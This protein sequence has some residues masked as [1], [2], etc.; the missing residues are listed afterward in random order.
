MET[1]KFHRKTGHKGGKNVNKK[2]V[3]PGVRCLAG[4]VGVFGRFVAEL[5]GPAGL[6]CPG[7][8]GG[9]PGR[10]SAAAPAFPR[11]AS[12]E[13]PAST[14]S[15]SSSSG[16]A[17][18]GLCGLPEQRRQRRS[19]VPGRDAGSAGRR[20]PCEGLRR[21]AARTARM[22]AGRSAAAYFLALVSRH[23]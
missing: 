17:L 13:E 12:W 3:R 14:S 20:W 16:L 9:G 19:A 6:R 5:R 15:S 23:L 22:T 18:L 11:G 1:P 4:L 2:E 7:P 8:G 21:G 10:G